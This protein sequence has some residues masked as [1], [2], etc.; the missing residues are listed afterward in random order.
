MKKFP[1]CLVMILLALLFA[2]GCGHG[3]GSD[4][5]SAADDDVVVDDDVAPDDDQ[6]DDDAVDDDAVDDDA[7]DDDTV[8][9]DAID[10]DA[11]D[12]DAADDDTVDD[13]TFLDDDSFPTDDCNTLE[14]PAQNGPY[15]IVPWEYG[16]PDDPNRQT[17]DIRRFFLAPDFYVLFVRGIR[18]SAVPLH[19]VGYYPDGPGPFPVML[20]VHGNHDPS[21]MSYP[22]YDYLTSHLATWGFIAMS[23]EED[24][25]NGDVSGEMDARGI[26][27]LRNLQLF[28]A[29]NKD[30]THP[31]YG[32]INMR[33]IGLAGHSRGGEAIGAAWL[34]NQ[35][36]DNPAD[37]LFDFHFDIRSLFAIAPVDGQ[38]FP[39]G[40]DQVVLRDV[41]YFIMHGSHD[42]DVSDFEGK[43]MYDRA[44]PVNEPGAADKALLFVQGA[45]HGQWNTVWAQYPDPAPPTYTSL[46]LMSAADQQMIGEIFLTAWFRWTLTGRACYRLM[47]AG[48]RD[49]P[50]FPAAAAYLNRQFQSQYREYLDDYEEDT[51]LQTGSLAGA[52]NTGADFDL[53]QENTIYPGTTHNALLAYLAPGAS[54][55]V[56]LPSYGDASRD[57]SDMIALAVGQVY[58]AADH[59]NVF[60]QD[61]NFSVRLVIDGGT[62]DPLP[63]SNYRTLISP[64][65]VIFSGAYDDSKSVT[66]TVRI[67]LADF[68]GGDP[69]LPSQVQAVILDFDQT[70]SGYFAVDDIQFTQW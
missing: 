32:K 16:G 25:L 36:L 56:D 23:V 5:D 21:E 4:D 50:S 22:G 66:D 44:L 42:G 48:E 54:Y 46:P 14:D 53:W 69:V 67:P 1:A 19:A 29:W 7:I 39:A 35:T 24:F 13:D 45:N 15:S 41:D 70:A 55:R 37:P 60:G 8:D 11:V 57:D 65:R 38:L 9:D 47:A 68:A 30:P 2:I 58:E 12:D 6:A 26:V 43:N 10:D 33:W 34:F 18:M 49:F 31:L 27:L 61:Q 17:T 40:F 28:R 62:S 59:Y 51:N 20:I 63:V 64:C 52:T 3:G